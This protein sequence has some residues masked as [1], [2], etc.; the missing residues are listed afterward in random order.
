[1]VNDGRLPKPVELDGESVWDLVQLDR[2][3]D[4][5]CGR[6]RTTL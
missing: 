1:M 2:A 5:L 3:I 6:R 4:R